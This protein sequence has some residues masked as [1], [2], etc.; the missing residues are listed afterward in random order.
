LGRP[1]FGK[2]Y[3]ED[4]MKKFGKN[5]LIRSHDPKARTIMYNKR[6]LTIFTSEAY[7][8]ERTVAIADLDKEIKTTDD[9]R[10]EEI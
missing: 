9:L 7:H 1:Q 3:F 5:V 2:D 8:R 6:C 4:K 10:I